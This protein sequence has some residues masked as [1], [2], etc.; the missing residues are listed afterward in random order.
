MRNLLFLFTLVAIVAASCKTKEITTTTE[1]ETVEDNYVSRLERER[2]SL[3]EYSSQKDTVY[4][5]VTKA[6]DQS[7]EIDN[8][9]DS[10]G[11]L[12]PLNMKAGKTTVVSSG[13]KLLINT[14]CD[15]CESR[16]ERSVRQ[17]ERE[18]LTLREKS[19]STANFH[20]LKESDISDT[21]RYPKWLWLPFWISMAVTSIAWIIIY[22]QFLK[23]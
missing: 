23:K 2:D 8:P 3:Y 20:S 21:I 12:K 16:F 4:V 22:F 19:D 1:K 13:N 15:E 17:W 9:C 5:E 18:R 7:I 6:Q 10:L 11:Q 14:A